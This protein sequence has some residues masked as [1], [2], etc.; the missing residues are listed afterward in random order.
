MITVSTDLTTIISDFR[1]NMAHEIMEALVSYNTKLMALHEI[2]R[3][4]S[5]NY[6]MPPGY[7]LTHIK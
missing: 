4:H 5:G 1:A 3:D 7:R 2:N 6:A